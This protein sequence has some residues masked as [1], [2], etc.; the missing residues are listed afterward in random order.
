MVLSFSIDQRDTLCFAVLMKPSCHVLIGIASVWQGLIGFNPLCVRYM[1]RITA[2]GRPPP[3]GYPPCQPV[4]RLSYVIAIRAHKS[5]LEQLENIS[6]VN[7]APPLVNFLGQSQNISFGAVDPSTFIVPRLYLTPP[8]LRS[9]FLYPHP[10][11]HSK[12][13]PLQNPLP[14]GGYIAVHCAYAL[15]QD[16]NFWQSTLLRLSGHRCRH[17]RSTH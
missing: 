8:I 15:K 11:L 2:Y 12:G 6:F 5:R 3:R 14:I 7:K 10:P 1:R 4:V 13:P 17:P 9:L 16:G